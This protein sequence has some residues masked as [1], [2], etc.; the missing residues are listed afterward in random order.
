MPSRSGVA[1]LAGASEIASRG[2][3]LV[4]AAAAIVGSL[5][6]CGTGSGGA[7]PAARAGQLSFVD[8]AREVG[9]RFRHGAF[10]WDESPDAA[11]M[12]G[13]GLCWLDYDGDGWLDLFVVNGHSQGRARR[14]G[15]ARR[16]A[17]D[18]APPKP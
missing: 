17:D 11:A 3:I 16:A 2:L 8:V 7:E 14:V 9:L 15:G 4:A 10:R 6:G 5:S 12:T 1:L 18:A 13:G